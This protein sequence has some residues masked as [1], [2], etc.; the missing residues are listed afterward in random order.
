MDTKRAL[1]AKWAQN[2]PSV[3]LTYHLDHPLAELYLADDEENL[4][5]TSASRLQHSKGEIATTRMRNRAQ[6]S[7]PTLSRELKCRNYFT[8]ILQGF[9]KAYCDDCVY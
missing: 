1:L 4:T 6:K 7:K 9:L 5:D 2:Q 8:F 3:P